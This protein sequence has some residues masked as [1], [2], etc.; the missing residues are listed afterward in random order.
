[1]EDNNIKYKPQ[2]TFDG[3]K[4]KYK[5]SFDFYLIDHN[6]CIEYDGKQHYEDIYNCPEEFKKTQLRD[7]IKNKFCKDNNIKLLRIKYDENVEDI[8]KK[9]L[10]L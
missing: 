6:M 7:K 10:S 3:C 4:Y 5:L 8:I 2:K 9:E 1:M